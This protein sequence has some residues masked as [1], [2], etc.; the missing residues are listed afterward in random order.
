MRWCLSFQRSCCCNSQCNIADESGIGRAR[1]RG[2]Q[3]QSE[4]KMRKVGHW[5]MRTEAETFRPAGRLRCRGVLCRSFGK[6]VQGCVGL[7]NLDV[8]SRTNQLQRSREMK[9]IGPGA[10]KR[11]ARVE[12][13]PT[14]QKHFFCFDGSCHV[15]GSVQADGGVFWGGGGWREKMS[16]W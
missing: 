8:Q 5:G 12:R 11:R 3:G 10:N 14:R 7:G 13:P 16:E 6:G 15:L 1:R 2:R 9:G 4:M